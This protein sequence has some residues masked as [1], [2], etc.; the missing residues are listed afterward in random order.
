M[1]SHGDQ[2]IFDKFPLMVS[3]I[4]SNLNCFKITKI[5]SHITA[6]SSI[7]FEFE[8]EFNFEATFVAVELCCQHK[9]RWTKQIAFVP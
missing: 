5:R 4:L 1:I 3:V 8:F 6:Y 9:N 7:A 2:K